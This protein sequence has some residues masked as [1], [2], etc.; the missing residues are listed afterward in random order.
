MSERES[1]LQRLIAEI[2]L[3]Q[4]LLGNEPAAQ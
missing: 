4:G 2:N 3:A 1:D